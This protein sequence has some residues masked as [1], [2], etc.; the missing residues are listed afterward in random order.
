M[1]KVYV[2]CSLTHAPEDFKA[3]ITQLKEQ[4]KKICEVFEFVGLT[5]G[6]SRDVY[7]QDSNMVKNCDLFVAE[8]SYPSTG[9]G[10]EIGLA[11]AANK[12]ILV[13]AKKDA[14][15]SRMILGIDS[16]TISFLRYQ[17]IKE[18]I[19]AIQEKISNKSV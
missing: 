1:K 16:S 7:L 6:T 3:S 19:P 8:C 11:L 12:P 9:L 13:I 10:L 14:K 15:V 17:N 2:G 18:A 5:A 4:I